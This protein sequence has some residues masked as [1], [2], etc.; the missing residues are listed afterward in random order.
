MSTAQIAEYSAAYYERTGRTEVPRDRAAKREALHRHGAILNGEPKPLREALQD[1]G[2]VPAPSK[3]P[4]VASMVLAPPANRTRPAVRTAPR[5]RERRSGC[6]L[7]VR[8]SRR[9]ASRSAGGGDSGDSDSDEP[10]EGPS[11]LAGALA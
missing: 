2:F 1:F 9:S 6:N 7:R 11:E 10:G 8:R 3:R 5:V 4:G